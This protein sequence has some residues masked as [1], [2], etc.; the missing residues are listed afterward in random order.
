MKEFTYNDI[1]YSIGENAKDNWDVL[2]KA[3]QDW[4]IIHLN[5]LP[6]PYVIIHDDN[7]ST[8][9]LYYGAQLCRQYTKYNMKMNVMY[10]KVSKVKKG[11]LYGEL[12]I[13]GKV[14]L[15]KI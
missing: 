15:I 7:P 11:A 2:D 8:A 14:K 3:H 9:A 13:T 10:T 4:T 6:S 12:L 5:K 1:I